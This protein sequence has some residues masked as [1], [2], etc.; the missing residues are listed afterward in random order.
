MRKRSKY[1]LRC[2]CR[3]QPLLAVYGV[4]ED[5]YLYVH[6]KIFKQGRIYGEV[7][8]SGG[9]VRLRC[10]EC[11]HWQRVRILQ[12]DNCAVLVADTEPNLLSQTS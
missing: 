11:Y 4:D 10:R 6:I 12:P 1:E 8:A 7:V 5:G 2:V 9:V 3:T